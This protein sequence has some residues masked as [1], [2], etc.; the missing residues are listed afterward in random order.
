[1]KNVLIIGAGEFGKHLAHKLIELKNE[2]RLIDQDE[3]VID[4]LSPELEN[5]LIGDCRSMNVMKQIGVSDYDFVVVAVGGNFQASLEITSNLKECGARF[6]VSQCQSDIQAKF[7]QMAGADKTV[8]SEKE[9][10]EKVA[11]IYNEDN[12]IDYISISDVYKIVKIKLPK[13]WA[14]QT[15]PELQIRKQYKLNLLAV[16]RG[17][18]V[19]VPDLQFVFDE[20]DVVLLLGEEKQLSRFFRN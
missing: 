3:A 5:T 9:A 18:K 19:T 6:I 13:K 10:A 20:H 11:L 4:A 1:M 16:E 2:V 14:G 12:L 17:G 8:Y 7:L 15:L